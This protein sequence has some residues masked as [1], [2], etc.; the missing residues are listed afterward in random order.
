MTSATSPAEPSVLS[1]SGCAHIWTVFLHGLWQLM[2]GEDWTE[3]EGETCLL[4]CTWPHR[5]LAVNKLT[6]TSPGGLSGLPTTSGSI[7]QDLNL[8]RLALPCG[9]L[10]GPLTGNWYSWRIPAHVSKH[11]LRNDS[12]ALVKFSCSC[13]RVCLF[14]RSSNHSSHGAGTTA[15]E[16]LLFLLD[17]SKSVSCQ[18]EQNV[19]D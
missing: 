10:K 2:R 9:R 11:R 8:A 15:S 16:K 13:L 6:H 14:V 7:S 19:W 4:A 12:A 17:T 3:A 18:V 1:G 5:L